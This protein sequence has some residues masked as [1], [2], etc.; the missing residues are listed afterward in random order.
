MWGADGGVFED[1]LADGGEDDKAHALPEG[2][3]V[4]GFAAGEL[5][6]HGDAEESGADVDAAEDHGGY[7]GVVEADAAEDGGAVVEEV[8]CAG[9]LLEHLKTH[10]ERDAVEHAGAGN[11]FVPRV[12]AFGGFHDLFDF[13][14]FGL[15]HWVGGG[16]AVE[17]GHGYQ[18]AVGAAVVPVES[19][20]FGEEEDSGA[21]NDGPD[22][23]YAHWDAV[24]TCIA[25][26][27]GAVVDAVCC[28]DTDGDK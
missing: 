20:G 17:L 16:L 10:G 7:E 11:G 2:G 18:T 28:E 26:G 5:A 1:E 13:V 19:G 12:V 4:E 15:D 14:G 8:V 25:A 27:L 24:G 23:S 6:G 3:D 21:E 22:E 9:E